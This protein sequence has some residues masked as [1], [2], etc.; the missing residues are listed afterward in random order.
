MTHPYALHVDLLAPCFCCQARQPF[1]FTSASDQAVCSFCVRHLGA[2]KAER[3]D[4]DHLRLWT[5]LFND[6][7][8]MHRS[9]VAA[10]KATIA[11]R[12]AAIVELTTHVGQLAALVAGHFDATPTDGVR[13]LLENDLI[14]RAE[15]KTELASRQ[16]DWAMAVIWR[17]GALHHDD[18]ENPGHCVCGRALGSCAEGLAID[19]VRTAMNDWGKKNVQLLRNGKR[20]G[21]PADHPAVIGERTR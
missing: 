16:I 13:G 5:E 15:R 19:P 8:E 7:Q 14:K 11:E 12:D 9:Y 21:L 2:E 4:S 20:N 17:I 3:R 1:H 18:A 10:T 6:E